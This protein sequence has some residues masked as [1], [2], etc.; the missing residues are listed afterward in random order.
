MT[1]FDWT[2]QWSQCN[3]FYSV[4]MTWNT[5]WKMCISKLFHRFVISRQSRK[6]VML[7]H[8]NMRFFSKY[9]IKFNFPLDLNCG[10][11][12]RNVLNSY[13]LHE[14]IFIF[15]IGEQ[16]F[17]LYEDFGVLNHLWIQP[18]HTFFLFL[19][20]KLNSILSIKW[21][22]MRCLRY[23]FHFCSIYTSRLLY[24]NFCI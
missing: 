3:I 10:L 19:C 14:G 6:F 24:L 5:I 21:L 20:V 17:K 7:G 15:K 18:S 4:L 9:A 16:R 1:G 8:L 12:W 22:V 2:S 13:I 23:F 11:L